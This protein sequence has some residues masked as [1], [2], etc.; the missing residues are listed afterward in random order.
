M[1]KQVER[2]DISD[3]LY[4]Y[5]QDNSKR[6][7]ARIKVAGKWHSKA[8][9]QKEKEKAIAMAYRLQIEYQFMADNDQLVSSKRFRD[10]AEKAINAMQVLINKS[11]AK[12]KDPLVDK[13]TAYIQLLRKYH[14]PFF[15]RIYITSIDSDKLS[16]FDIWRE[17]LLGRAPAKSTLLNHNAAFQ[18]VFKEAVQCKWMLVSQ[19]PQ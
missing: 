7:Y 11:K 17:E 10:V 19:V 2:H 1:T 13:Y 6:W 14:I 9:K 16:E 18:Q 5:L 3:E 12:D 8:T 4:V 15:D